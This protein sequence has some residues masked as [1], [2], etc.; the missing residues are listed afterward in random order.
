MLQ[1]EYFN[2]WCTDLLYLSMIFQAGMWL[3]R[4]IFTPQCCYFYQSKRSDCFFH[5]WT[6]VNAPN[7]YFQ[8]S[9]QNLLS[10]LLHFNCSHTVCSA[11][12]DN[13]KSVLWAVV[14]LYVFLLS[15]FKLCLTIDMFVHLS[16]TKCCSLHICRSWGAFSWICSFISLLS[17]ISVRTDVKTNDES[18]LNL[19]CI[20]LF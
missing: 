4:D 8:W 5:H 14:S 6:W 20:N 19:I 15:S 17:F 7:N 10:H 16:K 18:G 12:S 1:N 3:V 11:G 9:P 2:F 13:I